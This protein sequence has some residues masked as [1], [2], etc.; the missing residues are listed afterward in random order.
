M[1][2]LSNDNDDNRLCAGEEFYF[3]WHITEKCNQRC[4]H[5]Y[6]T[7]YES[8]DEYSLV[9][10]DA[11]FDA[12]EEALRAWHRKG[13]FS[14]TG[15]EPFLRRPELFHL[16]SR[17][18]QSDDVAYYDVLTNGSLITHDDLIRLK[19]ATS[20]RRVQVSLE[21]STAEES[22]AIRGEGTFAQTLDTIDHLK[23]AGIEVSVMY[24]V[25]RQNMYSIP[26]LID[27]LAEHKVDTFAVERFIPE[28]V[29]S[30]IQESMLS[31]A[32]AQSLFEKVYHLGIA[33]Q[34]I[35]VL[36]YRPLFAIIDRDDHT[37][38]AMC[39]V[40]INA[41]TVMHDGTV[42]PCRRLP[43][44]LGN[45]LTDGLFNIWYDSEFLW[46][47]REA[48]KIEECGVCELASLCR[49]CRAMAFHATGNPLGPDP[50]CWMSECST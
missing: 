40:G 13:S 38:G 36:L 22:D 8:N 24:T 47:I 46:D 33:E 5:C 50:H 30:S 49:G 45:I 29:G 23:G 15:G 14:L 18:D 27:L 35:R 10:L 31:K 3:Q 43:I 17:L 4:A 9:Q 6:H 11:C 16:M 25:S 26:A 21:G 48:D 28:G 12:M 39:S 1:N 42:F 32:E 41:L 20:L 2:Y 37:V 44:P 19:Q 34:R 7:S